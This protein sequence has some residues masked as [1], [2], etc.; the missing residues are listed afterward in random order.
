MPRKFDINRYGWDEKAGKF[1]HK[2][3]GSHVNSTTARKIRAHY[4]ENNL[5][6]P[7][8]RSQQNKAARAAK[9]ADAPKTP[10]TK[11]TRSN[12]FNQTKKLYPKGFFDKPLNG[13]KGKEW[14]EF[15]RKFKITER[16]PRYHGQKYKHSGLK[17]DE[18]KYNFL[19]KDK[20]RVIRDS[21]DKWG[22]HIKNKPGNA[23]VLHELKGMVRQLEIAVRQVHV[24]AEHFR[25]ALGHRAIEVFKQSFNKRQ[26]NSS[27]TTRWTRLADYTIRKRAKRGT[28][29]RILKE[30]GDLEDS[31]KF[32]KNVGPMSSRVYTDKVRA[33]DQHHKKH[34]I[35][36]AGYH[37]EGKGTYG[38]GWGRM[39]PKPYIKRQFMGHSSQL[40]PIKN[41]FVRK[42]VETF[43]FD[44]VFMAKSV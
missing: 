11:R 22:T 9:M 31:I 1:Y 4:Q 3:S 25:I 41:N 16:N 19:H 2:E 6:L 23:T 43:L 28:G 40:S 18:G 14:N 15:T 5:E 38:S 35:C 36:Y 17:W 24:N 37:N 29:S 20:G 21:K 13:M 33:N 32:Q 27:F 7:K 39:T 34:T 10:T 44:D 8:S 26:F 12:I 42:L 30:Y